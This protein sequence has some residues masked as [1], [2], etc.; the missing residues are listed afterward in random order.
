MRDGTCPKCGSS[1]IYHRNQGIEGRITVKTGRVGHPVDQDCYV[2]TDCGY[3]ERFL[4][5]E[6]MLG[7]IEDDEKWPRVEG[8]G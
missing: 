5:D 4:D 6:G 2:C 1:S 3:F 7:K 8:G